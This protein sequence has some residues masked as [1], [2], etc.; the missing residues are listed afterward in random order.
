MGC[1]IGV[2]LGGTNVRT[3]AF[4]EDGKLAGAKFARPS[5]AGEGLAATLEALVDVLKL[6]IDTSTQVPEAVGMAVPGHIDARNGVVRA[7]SNFGEWRGKY[8]E[9]W[10]DVPL[11]QLLEDRVELP[12]F[13]GNDGNLAALGEYRFGTGGNRAQC[14]VYLGLGTGVGGGVV[15]GNGS[16]VGQSSGP[17]VLQG[18]NGGGAEL[19][20]VIAQSQG[21]DCI[22]G[23]YGALEGYVNTSAIVTRAIRRL[24]QGWPS[25][26]RDW[27]DGDLSKLEPKHLSEAAEAGDELA[28]DLW[29][30][31]GEMLGV[32]VA[33]LI[34]VFGPD[35]VAIGGQVA[36]AG[37]W[38]MGPVR[39][40]ARRNGVATLFEQAA[41]LQAELIDDAGLLGGAALALESA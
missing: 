27:V 32:G 22:A 40:S 18:A 30:E 39:K 7:A 8:F 15:F 33:T 20:Y 12:V 2:D 17:L 19:G 28:I 6:A 10:R 36:K 21:A 11:K 13:L 14:L 4:T 16:V 9:F 35:V 26:V 3:A 25:T 23:T 5:R 38:L 37:E 1:V 31:V 41:I 34:N 29:E 24:D